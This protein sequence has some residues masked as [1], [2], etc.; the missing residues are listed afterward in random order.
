MFLLT[1]DLAESKSDGKESLLRGH[2]WTQVSWPSQKLTSLSAACRHVLVQVTAKHKFQNSDVQ[3]RFDNLTY[4]ASP[5]Y[6][7]LLC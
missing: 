3:A 6:F 4:Q 1:L 2:S 7:L 5:L